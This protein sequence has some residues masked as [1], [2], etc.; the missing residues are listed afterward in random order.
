MGRNY[1]DFGFTAPSTKTC[2]TGLRRLFCCELWSLPDYAISG[3]LDSMA[4]IRAKYLNYPHKKEVF[5][6]IAPLDFEKLIYNLYDSLGY[7]VEITK[8]SYDGG[9]DIIANKEKVSKKECLLIQCKRP[10]TRNIKVNEVRDLYGVIHDQKA[11]KG[12]LVCSTDFTSEAKKFATNNKSLELITSDQL[13]V[14][15]N[16]NFGIHWVHRINELI[17]IKQ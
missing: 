15:L 10:E 13:I 17:Q 11:T 2:I 7:K 9:I 3:L 5:K 6:E 16:E 12:V 1:L 8:K 4:I 14:L